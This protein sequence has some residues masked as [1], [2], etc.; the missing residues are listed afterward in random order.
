MSVLTFDQLKFTQSKKCPKQKIIIITLLVACN[1]DFV[2][3]N[4]I[5]NYSFWHGF[6]H[7]YSRSCK[8]TN[9]ATDKPRETY[10][11]DES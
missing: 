1:S 4:A 3:A 11:F 10:A 6:K 5:L 9:Y 7:L 2:F 8:Q